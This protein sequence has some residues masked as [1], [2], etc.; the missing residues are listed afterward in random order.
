MNV[1]VAEVAYA[2][3]Q[4]QSSGISA[5]GII[6]LSLIV[7]GV[8]AVKYPPRKM[9]GRLTRTQPDVPPAEPVGPAAWGPS[10]LPDSA[11][12][13][14]DL[15]PYAVPVGVPVAGPVAG[16]HAWAE[17]FD[18]TGIPNSLMAR[19]RPEAWAKMVADRGMN[20]MGLD[21]LS[22][23]PFGVDVHVLFGGRMNLKTTMDNVRQIE[24]GLDLDE[25]WKIQIKPGPTKGSGIVRIITH[26]PLS[27][28]VVWTIPEGRVRLADPMWISRTPFG[29]D[30]HLSVNQR[31][32]IFGTSGSGKSCAQRL[33]GAHVIQSEDADLEIWDLKFGT[34]SQHYA[35]KA[36]RIT[37]VPDAVNRVVWF[38]GT[39]FPR[40]AA[41]ML[42]RKTSSWKETPEDRAL[43]VIIDEGNAL[44]RGFTDVQLKS[45]YQVIEQGRAF[46][47][48]FVWATQ[49]P[50]AT[51]LPTE[52]RSQLGCRISL[53]LLSSEESTIVY[54]DDVSNGWAPHTLIGSGWMLIK[55]ED[56]RTPDESKARWLSEDVFRTVPLS[57][58]RPSDSLP[59]VPDSSVAP[60][61]NGTTTVSDD[62]RMVLAFANSPLGVSE[63]SRETGRSKSAVHG[64]LSRMVADGCVC[65]TSSD[66]RPVYSLPL[67]DD[68]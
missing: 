41:K 32:G 42:E 6:S 28:S 43:V 30:V 1:S 23:T 5:Q 39:E 66:N 11:G 51:N 31:I 46:G 35:G 15:A 16:S 57:G 27:E 65:K 53:L 52:I 68:H 3:A 54:K 4:G 19:L 64:A 60:M 29:E 33:I 20:G 67:A 38:I 63:L 40:R 7:T 9:L 8:L 47:V 49:Y 34:E 10:V 22:R 18:A 61:D 12:L 14:S 62:I 50:K 24:T 37:S 44:I 13:P 25:S 59:T 21:K 48:Y 17:D 58:D 36:T 2:L 56:H 55:D 45:L 26:D